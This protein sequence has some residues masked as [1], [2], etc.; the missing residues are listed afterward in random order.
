MTAPEDLQIQALIS[1]YA[2]GRRTPRETLARA[3]A[4]A[5]AQATNPIWTTLFTWERIASAL[6]LAEKRRLQGESL[7]LFGVPFGIKDN[8]DAKDCTTTCACPTFRRDPDHS[9]HVVEQLEAAGAIAFGKTNLDQFATGLVGTRSPYG[10]CHSAFDERYISGGSSSGSALAVALGHVSFALGTDTAGSGRV[11]AALNNVVG[12][13]PTRGLLSTRG[14]VPACRSLDCVSVFAGNVADCWSVLTTAAGFDP[15]DPFSRSAPSGASAMPKRFRFGV[16]HSAEFFGDIASARAFD[17]AVARLSELGGELVQIDFTPFQQAASLLYY[18]PWVAERAAAVGDFVAT[19]PA[20]LDPIVGNIIRQASTWNAIDAFKADYRLREL[21]ARVAQYWSDIDVLVVPTTPTT[22]THEQIASDPVGNNTKLGTY[23]NFTNLLDLCGIAI[24]TGFKSKGQPF[25]V[26]LLAPA[27]CD[28]AVAVLGQR[29]HEQQDLSVGATSI[30]VRK[31][32]P[33]SPASAIAQLPQS[34]ETPRARVRQSIT[35]A[36][37]GA[38]L[39]GQPLNSQLLAIGGRL[40]RTTRTAA[41]YRLFALPNTQPPK[42]G[43]VR[44]ASGGAAIEV[45]VYALDAEAFGRLTADVAAPL[46]IG[47]LQLQDDSWVKGFLC[48]PVATE[49]ALDISHYGGWRAYLERR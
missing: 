11:P 8:I 20:G 24:P 42:P 12:L 2:A 6:E 46:A 13:K 3:H 9:A 33:D 44:V 22:F 1:D 23:T 21:Q 30:P 43:L 48:E 47:N 36:V 37:V 15:E 28:A 39:S 19:N 7:P 18:G 10:A 25:G 5:R 38:H 45:E 49:N 40:E 4:L 35:I 26:T 17:L 16:P 31:P 32:S 41:R 29:L 34:A 27:F 14:V